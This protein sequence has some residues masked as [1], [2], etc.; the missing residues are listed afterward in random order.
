VSIP[1]GPALALLFVA[2]C[3]GDAL[4]AG[5]VARQNHLIPPQ[6][7]AVEKINSLSKAG[8][9]HLVLVR[10]SPEHD[11][12]VEYVF[13]CADID[14]SPIVWARDMGDAKNRDLIAYYPDRRVWLLEPDSPSMTITPYPALTNARKDPKI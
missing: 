2:C 8:E 9:R 12:H 7:R 10:Y 13:N 1:G 3:V 11:F 5:L 14:H 6:Q 4:V